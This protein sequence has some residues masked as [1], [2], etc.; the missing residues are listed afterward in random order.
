MKISQKIEHIWEY[1]RIQLVIILLV[2]IGIIYFIVKSLSNDP[3]TLVSAVFV[4]ADKINGQNSSFMEDYIID[5]GLDPKTEEIT[6]TW[7]D[8]ISNNS[9][10][11]LI[12]AMFLSGDTDLFVATEDVM[13]AFAQNSAMKEVGTYISESE[14][15]KYQNDLI[16]VT[17]P[18]TGEEYPCG[19][20]I[21]EGNFL[22][23]EN[24]Y[25]DLV[26]MG[27]A[28]QSDNTEEALKFMLY[29]L[30]NK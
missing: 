1:Y 10:Y 8:G 15:E 12:S 14:L 7:I 24:I 16:Y 4:G 5:S 28:Y 29:I 2:I 17:D 30:E 3:Y 9:E 26:Y 20:K 23:K 19:I 13:L 18:N 21:P 22:Y 27:I 6:P 11:Q 25:K